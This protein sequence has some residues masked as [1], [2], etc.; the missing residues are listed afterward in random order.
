MVAVHKVVVIGNTAV[1]KTSIINQFVY[2]TV[3]AQHQPTV[4]IDFFAKIVQVQDRPVRLQLWD[5]AGQERFHALIP[6][7]IRNS[8]VALLIYDITNRATFDDL[9]Q[10]HKMVADLA[11]PALIVVGNKADLE[12]DRTVPAEEARTY[13]ESVS[14]PYFETSAITPLNIQELFTAV[15]Q[16]P[17]AEAPVGSVEAQPVVE[18]VNLDAVVPPKASRGCC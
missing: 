13:A 7:Y 12:A 5:T 14:A 17:I 18:K 10:W 15:A 2:G 4:G 8:T 3:S 16:I 1:G 6:S 9:K 11:T